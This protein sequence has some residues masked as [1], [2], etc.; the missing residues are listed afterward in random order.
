MYSSK[1][2]SVCN[3]HRVPLIKNKTKKSHISALSKEELPP[4][5]SPLRFCLPSTFWSP[6]HLLP[7][8]LSRE[9]LKPGLLLMG[10]FRTRCTM[11]PPSQ[12]LSA[13][14]MSARKPLNPHFTSAN[15]TRG[16]NLAWHTPSLSWSSK[17]SPSLPDSLLTTPYPASPTAPTNPCPHVPLTP[18]RSASQPSS[19][20]PRPPPPFHGLCSSA[21]HK[22]TVFS[23]SYPSATHCICPANFQK[24]NSTA[25]LLHSF[26]VSAE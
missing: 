22:P 9:S 2:H 21:S 16:L 13:Q 5:N 1:E 19:L 20:S 14:T 6:C 12:P 25:C 3:F 10:K 18:Q 26:L 11:L 15:L 8:P 17:P 24:K 23:F 4:L 7:T